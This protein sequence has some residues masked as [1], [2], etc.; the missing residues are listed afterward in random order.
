MSAY[1]T[2]LTDARLLPLRGI[3]GMAFAYPVRLISW[4]P[5]ESWVP[6]IRPYKLGASFKGSYS[7]TFAVPAAL[8]SS[9]LLGSAM[10]AP[11]AAQTPQPHLARSQNMESR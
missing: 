8:I 11:A 9:K 5:L 6:L 3:H 7:I 4:L 10:A 2:A 1:R